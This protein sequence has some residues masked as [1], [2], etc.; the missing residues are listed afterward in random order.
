MMLY[1]LKVAFRNLVKNKL[2]TVLTIFGFGLALSLVIL[3]TLYSWKEMSMNQF[4]RDAQNIFKV[5]G[6]GTPNALAP[7]LEE[8]IPEIE[9]I[10]RVCGN[11]T[12]EVKNEDNAGF[13]IDGVLYT[14]NSFFDVFT[15]PLLAG[16][17]S[18]VLSKPFCAVV[19]ESTAHRL[20]GNAN[21]LGKMVDIQGRKL[22]I[23]GVMKD[24]PNNS[25]LKFNMLISLI[26]W[27][28]NTSGQVLGMRPKLKDDWGNF[29]FETFAKF[30]PPVDK[31]ALTEKI[32]KTIKEQGN[33]KYEVEHVKLY[34]LK[35]LYFNANLFSQF[36]RGNE[37]NVKSMIWIGII[38]LVLAIINFF[39][40]STSQGITRA[41]EIGVRKVNGGKRATLALQV[42]YES[43]ILAFLAMLLALF[44]ANMALP[45]F[46]RISSSNFDF[47]Y[48]QNWWQWTALFGGT[49]LLALVAGSYPAFYLSSFNALDVIKA[50]KLKT[51]GVAAFRTSLVVF[52][53]SASIVLIVSMLFIT[54]Q[55]DFLKHKDLGFEKDAILCIRPS[56]AVFNSYNTFVSLLEEN[57]AITGISNTSGYIGDYDSGFRL[58][59]KV[60]GEEK[61]MWSKQVYVDT[62]FFRTFGVEVLDQAIFSKDVY[63]VYLNQAAIDELNVNT[64]Q[65]V[66]ISL[67][68]VKG[69]YSP[70]AGVTDNFHFRS[71]KQGV[72]PLLIRVVPGM[73]GLI[74][75]RFNPKSYRSV[76]ELVAFC[77]NTQAKV[78]PDEPFR[79][80]FLDDVLARSYEGEKR[81]QTLVS[82]FTSFA[83][84]ISCLGLIGMVIFSNARRTKEIGVRKILGANVSSILG[85]L[86]S[87]YS[88]LIVASFAISM[89][90]AWYIMKKWLSSF[91]YRTE[92]N[93]WGFLLA[94]ILTYVIAILTVYIKSRRTATRNPVEALRYE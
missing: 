44:L 70:V 74:N 18:N 24:A 35:D 78:A 64:F 33:L 81:F 1:Y 62:A 29:S 2:N 69:V 36:K 17:S 10:V 32:Q 58:F 59:A 61:E 51:K 86:I 93:W 94:G 26:S 85:M 7:F 46:N 52:Q 82:L 22:E 65:N 50:V 80:D 91:P 12:M 9:S 87:G 53:F 72:Q 48:L 14:E 63:H 68:N 54:R 28:E 31:A 3:I 71:L 92:L 19:T 57:P 13:E 38:I 73:K 66:E 67:N 89:P 8:R 25:S 20:F 49:L 83:I 75:I 43:Y 16:N 5:S 23:T 37:K 76:N 40:L 77:R 84:I 39:N 21:P 55:L 47:L 15:F 88:K 56:M 60:D 42:I 11:S 30:R 4:H 27:E 79:Y 41:K 34:T 45:W 90:V 6:W